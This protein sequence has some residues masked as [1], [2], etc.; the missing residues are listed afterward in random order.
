MIELDSH[1]DY[2]NTFLNAKE[3]IDS[4]KAQG[5]CTQKILTILEACLCDKSEERPELIDLLHFDGLKERTEKIVTRDRFMNE[6]IDCQWFK[7]NRGA[8]GLGEDEK[9]RTLA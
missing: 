6:Y 3:K 1:E 7:L 2:D 8:V 9:A 4:V 5:R